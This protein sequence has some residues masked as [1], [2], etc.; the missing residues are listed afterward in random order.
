MSVKRLS[1]LFWYGKNQSSP[2]PKEVRDFG[3]AAPSIQAQPLTQIKASGVLDFQQLRFFLSYL[4]KLLRHP[5]L[6][7][8]IAANIA[9]D[10]FVEKDT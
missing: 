9:F 1:I 8:T 3:T 6:L 10:D 5:N 7:A 4:P 2:L